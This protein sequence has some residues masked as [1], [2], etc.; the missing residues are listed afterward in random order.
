MVLQKRGCGSCCKAPWVLQPSPPPQARGAAGSRR[1]GS[2]LRVPGEPASPEPRAAAAAAAAAEMLRSEPLGHSEQNPDGQKQSHMASPSQ[3]L[4]GK[5]LKTARALA[6]GLELCRRGE[7][8]GWSAGHR[9]L[10][11]AT[12]LRLGAGEHMWKREAAIHHFLSRKEML[13][14]LRKNIP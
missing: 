12:G 9:L 10:F 4:P 7:W 1:G 3:W 2:G 5:S 8:W 13:A 11:Q 14:C 6:E